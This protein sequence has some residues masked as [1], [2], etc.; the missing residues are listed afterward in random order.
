MP[1]VSRQDIPDEVRARYE[2]RYKTQL[3]EALLSPGLTAGQREHLR[4]QIRNL[5]KPKTY[6]ADS[7]PKAGA[8]ALPQ[9]PT[10]GTVRQMRKAEL[11]ALAN[12]LG[13]PDGGTK[14]ELLDRILAVIPS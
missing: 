9:V 10:A 14:K 7:P 2:G 5:G 6:R 4:E 3:K 11:L 12:Q 1:V 13:V 8:I